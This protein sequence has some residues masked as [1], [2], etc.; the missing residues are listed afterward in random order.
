MITD[1][2]S[3]SEALQTLGI[4]K[5]FVVS[6]KTVVESGLFEKFKSVVP[7]S[8]VVTIFYDT[9]E[10]PTDKAIDAAAALYD[11]TR[12]D[13]IVAFGRQAALDLAKVLAVRVRC[14]AS[15]E[16]FAED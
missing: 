10:K 7:N 1:T 2:D 12:S 14:D 5:P 9:P 8:L 6:E 13:G 16:T 15:L 11:A 4:E 3:F